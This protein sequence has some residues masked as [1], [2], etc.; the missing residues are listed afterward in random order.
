LATVLLVDDSRTML[1]SISAVL[2]KSGYTVETANDGTDGLAKVKA[3]LKPSVILTDLH[4][5]K[6]DGI[7]FIREVRKAPGVRFTPILMLTTE[8]QQSK[9]AE[10]KAAG[11]TGWIVKPVQPTDLLAVLQQVLPRAA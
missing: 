6:M 9:R 1:M 10:A 7:T 8:S 11:A 5:P 2:T 4:M 3:G